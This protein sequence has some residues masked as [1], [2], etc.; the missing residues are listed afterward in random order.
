MIVEIDFFEHWKTRALVAKTGCKESP[1]WLL[2]LWAH[3]Q[4]RKCSSFDLSADTLKS[5]C[6]VPSKL[7]GSDWFSIL[8]ECQFIDGDENAWS[9]HD[10][11][12]HNS[13]LIKNWKGGEAN[14]LRLAKIAAKKSADKSATDATPRLN[15]GLTPA[16]ASLN[17][18]LTP[19]QASLEHRLSDRSDGGDRGDGREGELASTHVSDP[20]NLRE[21]DRTLPETLA[22]FPEF[23]AAWGAWVDFMAERNHGLPPT[24]VFDEH[25]KTLLACATAGG[26][27]LVAQSM[28]DATSR[29]LRAPLA[30]EKIWDRP[31]Q[32][33]GASNIIGDSA[34][35]MSDWLNAGG[36]GAYPDSRPPDTAVA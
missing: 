11:E 8:K 15:P 35:Q 14:R 24:Q 33:S 13:Q 6:C 4:A 1:L 2:R 28:R 22:R 12:S 31:A 32:G 3:C 19:A 23:R 5:I 26:W 20:A 21:S 30:P 27:P 7:K 36:T 34:R 29:N 9:V 18:S 10:W 25:L 17:P 16:Q